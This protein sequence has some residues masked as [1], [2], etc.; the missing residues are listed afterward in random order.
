MVLGRFR[1]EIGYKSYIE[2]AHELHA[3]YFSTPS[4]PGY[5]VWDALVKAGIDPWEVNR[6]FLDDA[7]ARGDRFFV[8]ADIGEMLENPRFAN[9]YL[10]REL[11]Y[12][13]SKGYKREGQ[14][15]IPGE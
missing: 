4:S 2:K 9:T 11:E 7:V 13:L 10:R 12:L 14:W 8:E 1:P 6:Q 5:D 3:T 15:L